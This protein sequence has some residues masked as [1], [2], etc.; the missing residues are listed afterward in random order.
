M[1]WIEYQ[2]PK[3]FLPL[4]GLKAG[5][6]FYFNSQNGQNSRTLPGKCAGYFPSKNPS[7]SLYRG[8]DTSDT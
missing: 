1:A 4:G 6:Y 3:D 7:D 8:H 2:L 5:Q